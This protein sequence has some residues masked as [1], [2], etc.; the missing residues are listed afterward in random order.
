MF[1]VGGSDMEI[2]ENL[3]NMVPDT[4]AGARINGQSQ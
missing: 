2:A 3:P 4:P 1:S